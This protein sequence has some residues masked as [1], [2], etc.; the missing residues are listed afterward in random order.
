[1]STETVAARY[2]QVLGQYPTGVVVVTATDAEGEP[3][4]MTVGTF[5]AVSLDPPLVAFMPQKSS[6]SWA[7]LRASGDRF[8]INILADDQE[9]ICRQV[10]IRKTDKLAGIAWRAS[11]GG[12]P[13]IENSVAYIDCTTVAVHDAGDHDIVIGLVHDLDMSGQ[14]DPLLFFRGGYGSFLPQSLAA[15][16]ADLVDQL[17]LVDLARPHMEELARRFDTEVTA[18]SLVRDELVLTASAGRAK[19][20]TAPTRVGQRLPFMPPLG[21]V[22]AAW[23]D[24]RLRD[25]WLEGLDRDSTPE[26]ITHHRDV[27]E[28]IRKRGYSIALGHTDG[29]RLESVS[30]R[31]NSKDPKVSADALRDTIRQVTG[32]YNAVDLSPEGS[33][34]LRSLSA[35]VFGPDGRVALTLT[36]WGPPGSVPTSEIDELAV[37][38]ISASTAATA[39]IG[40]IIPQARPERVAQR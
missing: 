16:D 20:A 35:P 27:V 11:D 18:I 30:T 26:Q 37:H 12:N 21:S 3:L 38:L 40:G 14:G 32:G 2:R 36:V 33:Y 6:S 34:E 4:G 31:A 24:D 15:G 13:I 19:T 8:C 1:M 5:T 17:R 28:L 23:G 7:A 29:E 22:F 10:A 9:D 25:R 39:A